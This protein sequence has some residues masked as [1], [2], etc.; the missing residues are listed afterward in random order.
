[1]STQVERDRATVARRPFWHHQLS[2]W[3]RVALLIGSGTLGAL[4]LI[5]LFPVGRKMLALSA[6]PTG[7][8][9]GAMAVYAL[10]HLVRGLRLSVLVSD[11]AVGATRILCAH[12]LTSG[13]ITM[14]GRG[15]RF[16]DAGYDVPKF[17]IEVHGRSL[18]AWSLMSLS[19]WLLAG[20]RVVFV[21][22]RRRQRG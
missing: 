20:A 13:L 1:M 16:R 19:S 18:F 7:A 11:P 21:G 10:G 3:E 9:I 17:A 8:L 22:S 6:Q 15:Q 14:A 2:G 4:C 5:T 12:V